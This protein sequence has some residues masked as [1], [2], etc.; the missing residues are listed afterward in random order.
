MAHKWDLRCP[1]PSGLVV[2]APVGSPTGPTRAQTRTARWRR[3]SP[4][5]YVPSSVPRTVEQRIVEAAQRLPEGG[6]VSGW[7]ALR[8]AGA[9]LCDGLG[10]DGV[11]ELPVALVG[12]P[13]SNFRPGSGCAR[14]RQRLDPSEVVL[15]HG[16]P[17]TTVAR[18]VLDEARAAPDEREAVVAVDIA[19]AAGLTTLSALTGYA[20]G[21]G[22]VPGV[23]RLRSALRL[24]DR[25]SRSPSE[26]RM[27]LI[28]VVD[29]GLPVPRCNWPVAN[30]AGWRIG[31]PD[32]LCEQLA[33]I[34]EFDGADHSRAASRSADAGK[35]SDYRDAGLEVFRVTGRDLGDPVRVLRRMRAAV[36]RAAEWS[37]PRRW[38]LA[39][40]PGPL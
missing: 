13:T 22:R 39:A 5:L 10:R 37:R 31:R 19:V 26:T 3:T 25:R 36:D 16:V 30:L 7:A 28:W 32:L 15:R 21:L 34:G 11:T 24:A 29:G 4:G 18:A 9:N 6:A 17:C 27:R 14:H 40:D 33:V 8:L 23:A 38:M 12:P 20:A 2:P 1:P 35:E